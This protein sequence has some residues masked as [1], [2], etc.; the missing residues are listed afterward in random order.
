MLSTVSPIIV[1]YDEF[2][3]H[4]PILVRCDFLLQISHPP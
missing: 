2:D 4:E 3:I 1:G